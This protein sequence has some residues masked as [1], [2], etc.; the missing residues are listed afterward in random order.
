V[1]HVVV[2]DL[3]VKRLLKESEKKVCDFLAASINH[4]VLHVHSHPNYVLFLLQVLGRVDA[5]EEQDRRLRLVREEKED[6]KDEAD[7]AARYECVSY[8]RDTYY[9]AWLVLADTVRHTNTTRQ[10]T[11]ISPI[12]R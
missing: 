8:F 12:S 11:V 6:L 2:D 7:K 4:P 3:E 5:F 10:H 1:E 9:R